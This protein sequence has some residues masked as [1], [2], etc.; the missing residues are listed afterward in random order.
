MIT[1]NKRGQRFNIRAN[2]KGNM[3]IR[4]TD[5]GTLELF[6]NV[7]CPLCG[8]DLGDCVCGYFNAMTFDELALRGYA[9][10]VEQE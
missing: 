1:R 9:C 3:L 8:V 4:I 7:G 6:N 2:L 5:R 10:Y